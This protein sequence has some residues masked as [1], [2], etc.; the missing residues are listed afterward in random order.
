L[1]QLLGSGLIE[2]RAADERMSQKRHGDTF[3]E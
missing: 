1:Y 2:V 3:I